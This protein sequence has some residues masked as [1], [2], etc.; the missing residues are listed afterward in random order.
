[1][2]VRFTRLG[3]AAAVRLHAIPITSQQLTI[4]VR[5]D[6]SDVD[7][8]AVS[9]THWLSQRLGTDRLVAALAVPALAPNAKPT[10]QLFSEKG[11]P[12]GYA[13][14]SWNESTREQVRAEAAAV[15]RVA[16][17][18]STIDVPACL[19]SGQ[20][21]G[22][23]VIVTAPMPTDATAWAGSRAPSL[24]IVEDVA[25]TSRMNTARLPDSA[26]VQRIAAMVQDGGARLDPALRHALHRAVETVGERWPH[27]ELR[28]GTW[29][30]DWVP[31]NMATASG[32]T[33][34]W[35]WEHS[36]EGVPVGLDLLHWHFQH[37]FIA[38]KVSLE[39]SLRRMRSGG[40][41]G[42]GQ[43]QGSSEAAE[44]CADLY[45]LE[46]CARYLAM[47]AAGSG[48]APRFYPDALTVL[49]RLTS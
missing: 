47:Q 33:V 40:T 30:G 18:L 28:E 14:F 10:L 27:L 15:I 8:P 4:F 12:A 20:W 21:G 44:A 1:M 3:V 49:A 43:L 11:D 19:W 46:I 36:R 37:G 24:E 23:D 6:V 29:H 26:I 35:D 45:S 38:E 13:K 16:P 17:K 31:W 48:W 7:L 39:E 9:P 22:F 2:S 41:K 5:R 32:R 25:R 42:V 34:V